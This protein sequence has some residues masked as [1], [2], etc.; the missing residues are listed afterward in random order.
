MIKLKNLLSENAIADSA[1]DYLSTVIK[2]SPFRGQVFVVGGYV[3]DMLLGIPSKDVDLVITAPD[4]GIAFSNWITKK[5]GIYSETNPLTYP[6]FGTAKFNL[7][8]I[9]HNGVNLGA[10]D[11]E[12]VM[13]RQEKYADGSRK[14]E[15]E[16]GTLKQDAERRDFTVNSLMKDLTTGE[17]VDPTGMGLQ[18]LKRGVVRSAIDPNIIFQE[19][20]LRMLRAIR[21]ASKYNWELPEY[22][23]QAI[24]DNADKISNISAE[25]VREEFDKMLMSPKPREAVRLMVASGLSKHTIPELDAM[26]GVTQNAYHK[27][28]VFDHSLEVLSKTPAEPLARIAGLFHDVGKPKTRTEANGKVQF[29]KH[30]DVGA[31]MVRDIMTRLKYPNASIDTVSSVVKNHMRLKA[32]G[33]DG[34][35]ISDK[36]LR[37]F[38]AELGEDMGVA[39][40]VMDADNK[41]HSDDASMPNQITAL[42]QRFDAL[43]TPTEKVTLPINGNDIMSHLGLKGGP[44]LAVLLDVVQDA[45]FEDPSLSPEAAIKLVSHVY[46]DLK[47]R[48]KT[49][50]TDKSTKLA[51]NVPEKVRNPKTDND[52]LIK[53]ALKYDADHPAR[54]AAER[55]LKINQ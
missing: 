26:V 43:K 27:D 39:L 47:A 12:A 10:L 53:T 18:D 45:Y 40:H 25:R 48:S 51:D 23:R 16:Y 22:M 36:A 38:A 52:I 6:R 2:T 8:G 49:P 35:G 14:P 44:L 42:R 24:V 3:R 15:V 17:V 13:T 29:L 4:G 46:Q 5:L 31:D 55:I 11:I 34:S 32:A 7:R 21:F 33:P 9:T 28:D 1:L 20:P 19:D 30:E 41:S 54:K 50:D 37:R